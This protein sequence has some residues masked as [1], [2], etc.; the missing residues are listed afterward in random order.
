L[1]DFSFSPLVALHFV[2]ADLDRY[3]AD[4]VVW[5]VNFRE[6]NR[7]LPERL[8]AAL[9]A[10]GS[11]VFTAEALAS[12]A[13]SLPDLEGLADEPFLVFLE[14]PSL[15]DRIVNQAALFALLSTARA[16]PGE[17]LDRHSEVARRVL[18][19]AALKWE[20]RDRLDQANVTE[21]V[22]FPGLEGLSAWLR[23]YYWPKT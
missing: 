23:R 18:V 20:V 4:G 2:T 14:P 12:V 13:E 6:T 21:R 3:D 19:P 5:S 22:L 10:E 16:S 17:W 11:D 7:L 1:L 15:D 9:E 8:R